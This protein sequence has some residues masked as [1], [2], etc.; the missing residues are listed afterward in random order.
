M[1][2]SLLA[3]E[4]S[5]KSK[6]IYHEDPKALHV[7]TL[8]NHCYF[9]PFGKHQ[10]PFESREESEFFELLN[11]EWGFTFYESIVDMARSY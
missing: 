6:M 1:N 5:A 4:G 11:G 10:N 2:I 7:N 8:A 9:V 3:K